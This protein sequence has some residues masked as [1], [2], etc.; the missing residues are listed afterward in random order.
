MPTSARRRS[1]LAFSRFAARGIRKTLTGERPPTGAIEE[2][3]RGCAAFCAQVDEAGSD[4][5]LVENVR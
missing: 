2:S 5:M 3:S 1:A 4:L